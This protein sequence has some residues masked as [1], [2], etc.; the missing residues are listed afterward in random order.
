MAKEN[1]AV[2]DIDI[3]YAWGKEELTQ[4]HQ[5]AFLDYYK[6]APGLVLEIG[7]GQGAFLSLMAEKGIKA[8]GLDSSEEAVRTCRDKGLDAVYGRA[9]S[10][11]TS[12]PSESLGGI[13]CAHVIEHMHPKEA[14]SLLREAYRTLKPDSNFVII[15]PNTKDLRTTERFWLDITHVRPY[16]AKLLVMLLRREGFKKIEVSES[17]ELGRNIY[18]K[19]AKVV[20]RVWFMGYM[21]RGDLVVIA[22][23]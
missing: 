3:L 18:E 10:H 8:Y 5:M 11:L 20:L 6:N 12:L 1:Q 7:S 22:Q 14:I 19:I 16:P 13:F 9:V 2:S 17:K 15:T 21:F 4:R 23:R